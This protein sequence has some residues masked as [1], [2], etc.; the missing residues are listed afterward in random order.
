MAKKIEIKGLTLYPH[1]K[2]VFNDLIS[3]GFSSEMTYVIKSQRQVGKSILLSQLLLYAA[4]N[5]PNSISIL[6][7][8]TLAQTRKIFHE[9]LRGIRDAGVVEKAN[10]SL[11]EMS[12]INGS[13]IFFKSAEQ[14][15]NLRG[16]SVRNGG[17]CVA[18]ESAYFDDDVFQL[19][20]PWVNVSK[21]PLI[22]AS[23]PRTKTGFFYEQYILGMSGNPLV[24]SYDWSQYDLSAFLSPEKKELLKKTLPQSQY[25]TEVEGCFVD[26]L[27]MVFQMNLINWRKR[28]EPPKPYNSIYLGVDFATGNNNDYTVISG[29]SEHGE[30]IILE[31]TNNMEPVK[32]VEWIASTVE[33]KLDLKKIRSFACEKNSLGSVYISMLRGRLPKVRID[34][35]VTTNESKREIIETLVYDIG[36]GIVTLIDDDEQRKQFA[37]YEMQFTPT[38]K[39]TYNGIAGVHDDTVLSTAIARHKMNKKSNYNI[40]FNRRKSE[41]TFRGKYEQTIV[42]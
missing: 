9:L 42:I 6:I 40:S 36:N 13:Q 1:Q 3:D 38:G 11:L 41:N 24:K 5:H 35:F 4:L 16:Y 25:L 21:A 22:L 29:F 27:G 20:L 8:I 32:Q 39:I 19:I 12:F 31:Y 37:S 30:Q 17:I 34:E 2:P 18:D 23:S 15:N 10:E 7:S 28:N 14:K 33:N 26:E